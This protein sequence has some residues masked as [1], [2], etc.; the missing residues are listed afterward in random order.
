MSHKGIWVAANPKRDGPGCS[1]PLTKEGM[2]IEMINKRALQDLREAG[3]DRDRAEVIAS[4]I[5]DWTQL[6]TKTDLDQL[7]RELIR[8]MTL[9]LAASL[10][11]SLIGGLVILFLR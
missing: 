5:P 10:L 2:S 7:K 11:I 9:L 8:W 1:D 3:M 6:A 4:H